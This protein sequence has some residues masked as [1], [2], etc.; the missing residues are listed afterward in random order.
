MKRILYFYHENPLEKNAGNKTRVIN[1]LRYFKNKGMVVDFV[2]IRNFGSTWTD[3]D[4]EV[5]EK[6]G[7]CRTLY[8]LSRKPKGKNL[9]QYWLSY[10][11]PNFFFKL[12][13]NPISL[14]LNYHIQK[15]FENVLKNETYD[16]IIINYVYWGELIN[17]K[18][19]LSRAMTILDTHDFTTPRH[20]DDKNFSLADF[21]GNE[22]KQM[23]YFDQIWAISSD[24]QYLFGQFYPYKTKL[25]P[26]MIDKPGP[27][28]LPQ[29]Y[30]FIYVASDNPHNKE[31]AEWFFS[32]VFP[33]IPDSYR[34]LVVGKITK[35]IPDL[36]NVT[37]ILHMDKIEEAYHSSKAAICP[38]L[39]G[40][41][42]KIKVVEALAHGLPVICQIRGVDG[43]PNKINNGCLVSE[44]ATAFGQNMLHV[45]ED[46]DFHEKHRVDGE[47][48]FLD[49]FQSEKVY[50]KLDRYFALKHEKHPIG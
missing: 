34:L 50:K 36:P 16:H 43:L 32:K 19:L 24:E 17:K 37:K 1:L 41:G 45:V 46:E 15:G 38:M 44:N 13:K 42:L 33:S 12:R 25:V 40:T 30:E 7:F 9:F 35:H 26:F 2:S 48:L 28:L 22:I 3:H 49:Y 31:A 47:S 18:N 23:R 6:S 4:K 21:F 20:L 27:R 29:K 14:Y 11:I 10:K 8:L 5:F 39:H